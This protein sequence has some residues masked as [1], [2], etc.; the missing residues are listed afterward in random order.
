M[1]M[2][3]IS[4]NGTVDKWWYSHTMG[5]HATALNH[6]KASKKYVKLQKPD[7]KEHILYDSVYRKFE[8]MQK[9]ENNV[10]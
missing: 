5:W 2:I 10:F 8:N 7:T 4:P 3:N 6:A 1:E 9:T